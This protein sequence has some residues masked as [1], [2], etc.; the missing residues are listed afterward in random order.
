MKPR[1]RFLFYTRLN[2]AT[3]YLEY[4]SGGST[5]QASLRPGLRTL[6]SVES[7]PDWY[8]TVT[9][10]VAASP[11][12]S[13]RLLHIKMD[14]QPNTWGYPGRASTLEDWVAYSRVIRTLD[15]ALQASL[16]LVL[17][18]GRFRV[19]CCL[20]CY[21]CV[22]DDCRIIFDDF[23]DRPQYHVVLDFY[24]IVEQTE[25]KTLVVLKK[26]P[27]ASPPAALIARYEATAN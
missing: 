1:D 8:A 11:V 17:I 13:D 24:E 19:A 14:T 23:L 3:H 25:D 7:D 15:P 4:G 16:D 2:A 10:L 22:S 9:R 21:D 18:D 20:N 5:V 12:R 6:V 27:G 26:K